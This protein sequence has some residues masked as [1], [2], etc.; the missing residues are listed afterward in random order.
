MP[1][2]LRIALLCM[3]LGVASIPVSFTVNSNPWI[4]WLGNALGSLLSALIVI[5]IANRIT[6]NKFKKK[7]SKRRMTRKVVTVFEEGE[8]NKKVL[9]ARIFIDSHGLKIFSF[10]SPVFPGVLIATVAVYLLDLDKR[11]FIRWMIA[12]IFLASGFYVFT[13][14]HAFIE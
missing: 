11:M 4:V 1:G 10:L 12:G 3:L 14:W 8:D 13:Y 9:K 6:S 2:I 7:L 5:F